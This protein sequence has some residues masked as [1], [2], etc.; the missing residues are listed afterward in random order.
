MNSMFS[1]H[2][3]NAI[4]FSTV[5]LRN[6]KWFLQITISLKITLATAESGYG[7]TKIWRLVMGGWWITSN[8]LIHFLPH[9]QKRLFHG[10]HKSSTLYCKL[11]ILFRKRLFC[12]STTPVSFVETFL[13]LN[14]YWFPSLGVFFEFFYFCN[15]QTFSPLSPKKLVL[16]KHFI[17]AFTRRY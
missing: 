4:I 12:L 9:Y 1:P 14:L 11:C 16:F 17:T 13:P 6:V 8:T 3:G 2:L 10:L 7:G 5:S 15:F